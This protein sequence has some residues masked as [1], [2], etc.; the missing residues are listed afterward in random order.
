[1]PQWDEV[2]R[3]H[4]KFFLKPQEDMADIVR[5]FRQQKVKTVLDLGC[6]SGRHTVY[7]AQRGFRVFGIDVSPTG[8]ALTKR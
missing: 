5:I 4:G 1:M 6:G 7:L 3:K 2:F 8:I